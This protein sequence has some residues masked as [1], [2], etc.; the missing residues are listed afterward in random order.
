M[1]MKFLLLLL[2]ILFSCATNKH[3][4]KQT[5]SFEPET[6]LIP[7]GTFQMGSN[8]GDNDEKPIR[9]VTLNGFYLILISVCSFQFCGLLIIQNCS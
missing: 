4:I 3:T 9:T 6:I 8:D 7:S 1:K 5:L 2:L